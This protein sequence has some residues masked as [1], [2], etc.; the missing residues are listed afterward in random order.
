M[1]ENAYLR[2]AGTTEKV[3]IAGN[4]RRNAAEE[5]MMDTMRGMIRNDEGIDMIYFHNSH[6]YR[7]D[8]HVY[9]L[10]YQHY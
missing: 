9:F 4:E 10:Q 3:V 7:S 6:I 2:Y 5:I 8:I 1:R